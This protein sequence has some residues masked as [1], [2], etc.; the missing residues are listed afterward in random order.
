M[1]TPGFTTD[2]S[3]K[4][5][6]LVFTVTK[7]GLNDSFFTIGDTPTGSKDYP[8]PTTNADA[9][10][11]LVVGSE[12]HVG[13]VERNG[14]RFEDV[15]LR[16]KTRGNFSVL[17][18]GGGIGISDLRDGKHTI[19]HLDLDKAPGMVYLEKELEVLFIHVLCFDLN[20]GRGD[21]CFGILKA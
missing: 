10:G 9:I 11:F 5:D 8:I 19:V 21:A 14:C 20:N 12:L 16:A 15:P 3:F 1:S 13:K 18:T 2:R 7:I 17:R 6:S 4:L